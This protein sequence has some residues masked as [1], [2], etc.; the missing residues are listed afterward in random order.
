MF[1][2]PIINASFNHPKNRYKHPI[3]L[4]SGLWMIQVAHNVVRISD[5][6]SL[7]SGWAHMSPD[8]TKS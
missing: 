1:S 7:G 3:N 5:V 6:N 2:E 8:P 4:I